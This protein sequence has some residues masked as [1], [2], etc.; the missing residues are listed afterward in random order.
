[1]FDEDTDGTIEI[2]PGGGGAFLLH[3]A[4]G[5]DR[6]G[7][8]IEPDDVMWLS[9]DPM[10]RV[11]VRMNGNYTNPDARASLSRALHLVAAKVLEPDSFT[12]PLFPNPNPEE[13]NHG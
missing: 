4:E 8:F 5:E 2:I 7:I 10:G 6:M 1:M 12:T 11:T 9:V 13:P 3:V